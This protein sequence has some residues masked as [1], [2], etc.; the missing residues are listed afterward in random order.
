MPTK[1]IKPDYGPTYA[2]WEKL[3]PEYRE[4]TPQIGR[5]IDGNEYV[6]WYQNAEHWLDQTKITDRLAEIAIE[7]GEAKQNGTL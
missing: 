3:A 6:Q 1:K 7:W 2:A 5:D 4:V